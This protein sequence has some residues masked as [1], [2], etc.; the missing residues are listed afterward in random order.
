MV[1]LLDRFPG[2]VLAPAVLHAELQNKYS[3]DSRV[4]QAQPRACNGSHAVTPL[5]KLELLSQPFGTADHLPK[6]GPQLCFDKKH[7]PTFV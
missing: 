1:F 7:R 4:F 2:T 3:L 5:F 6:T